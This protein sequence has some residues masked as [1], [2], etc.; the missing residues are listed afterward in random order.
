MVVGNGPNRFKKEYL[1]FTNFLG[2]FG[3]NEIAML[4]T[5]AYLTLLISGLG[6]DSLTDI[7]YSKAGGEEL[8]LDIVMPEKPM[9]TPIPTV[10]LIHG[11]AWISGKRQDMY[12]M[13][14]IIADNGMIAVPVS[15]RLA[16][17]HKYPSMFDDV[18]TAVRF[19][20]AN[21]KKYN[22][23]PV[24]IGAC[25]ASAGG[26]LALLTGFTDTYNKKTEE[27]KEYSSQTCV[28]FDI[29]GPTDMTNEQDYPKTLD[30]V[31]AMVVGKPRKD[32]KKELEAA[33]PIRYVS[34]TSAPVFIFQGLA[35]TLVAPNQS[36]ILEKAL[37]EA[38]V[39]VEARYLEGVGHEIPAQKKEV[40]EAVLAG[41]EFL[42]KHLE[43]P[44]LAVKFKK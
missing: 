16:P 5:A 4:L 17:K 19:L 6:E 7:T 13:A 3:Y 14:K 2:N 10:L 32:S 20:R 40:Q 36:R 22:I 28:V 1:A 15:Y 11:G 30:P 26:H 8:K 44:T 43:K 31:F 9:K 42:K 27:Y 12:P 35:D 29:F 33:S 25:G 41:I 18:Q 39:P 38:K 37:K 23:D 34:S 21:A 24:R